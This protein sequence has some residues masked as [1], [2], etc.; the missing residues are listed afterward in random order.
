M[1]SG[2]MGERM[3]GHRV[4]VHQ[5]R[6]SSLWQGLCL[7]CPACG[8][9][10]IYSGFRTLERCS[11][12]R[13]VFEREPGQFTGAVYITLMATQIGFGLLWFLMERF[14]QM[15]AGQEVGVGLAWAATFPALVYRHAKGFFIAIVHANSGLTA[16][17][18]ESHTA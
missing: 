10:R 6:L 11:H 15:T 18:P 17:D 8:T 9:G 2:P 16:D 12:C 5:T 4:E 13:V 7:I 3:N 1:G 14:T